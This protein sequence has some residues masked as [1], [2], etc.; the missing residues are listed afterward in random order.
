MSLPIIEMDAAGHLVYANAAMVALMEYAGIRA[1]GFSM[2]LPDNFSH[3]ASRWLYQGYVERN[4][5]VT[6][7]HRQFV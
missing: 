1:D 3:N 6:V 5:E 7:G 4:Y 2:A